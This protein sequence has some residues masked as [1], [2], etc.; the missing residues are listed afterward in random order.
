MR[1]EKTEGIVLRSLEYKDRQRIITV[2]TAECGL[3]SLIV[4]GISHR[5][6]HLLALTS[7]FC[8]AEFHFARGRSNLFRFIDGTVTEDHLSLRQKFSF[9]QTAGSMANAILRSQLPEKP[10]PTLYAFFCAYLKQASLFEA[11]QALTASFLLKMLKHEGLL[12]L[13]KHCLR[14]GTMP[15]SYLEKGESLCQ[16]HAPSHALYFSDEE[17]ASLFQLAAAQQFSTLQQLKIDPSLSQKIAQLFD[18]RMTDDP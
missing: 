12:A 1:D 8:Q 9:L 16:D 3:I 7:P 2:F 17:W 13:N 18:Q 6:Q 15:S 4:K 5:S 11:P 14:C 10:S